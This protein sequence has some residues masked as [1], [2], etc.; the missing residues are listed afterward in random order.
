MEKSKDKL[1]NKRKSRITLFSTILIILISS[2]SV[3]AVFMHSDLQSK[4]KTHRQAG[5]KYETL[6]SVIEQD[7]DAIMDSDSPLQQLALSYLQEFLLL[8]KTIGD[9]IVY[10]QTHPYTFMQY[11][12]DATAMKAALKINQINRIINQTVAYEYGVLTLYMGPANNY[13]YYDPITMQEIPYYLI[14]N[15]YRNLKAELHP[16]LIYWINEIHGSE[17]EILQ[18]RLD[19]WNTMMYNDTSI[20]GVFGNFAQ[21]YVGTLNFWFDMQ[22]E[23]YIPLS[24]YG[25]TYYQIRDQGEEYETKGEKYEQAANLMAISLILLAIAAVIVAFAVSILGRKYIWISLIIGVVVTGIGIWMFSTGI[26][27]LGTVVG[28]I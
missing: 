4:A 21:E 6:L 27:T 3:I 25:N 17:P 10:N 9:M 5:I 8:N 18:I 24:L 2:L 16:D 26:F 7:I 28:G 19:R 13:T 20:A 12:I 15:V 1:P 22:F 14:D 23:F 11:E